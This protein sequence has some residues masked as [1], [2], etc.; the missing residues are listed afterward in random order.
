MSA[1]AAVESVHAAQHQLQDINSQQTSH[2]RSWVI[3]VHG[4]APTDNQPGATIP[5][6]LSVAALQ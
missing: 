2:C 6:S 4:A 1:S 5:G 3:N